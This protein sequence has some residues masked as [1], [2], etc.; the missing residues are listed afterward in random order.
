MLSC[1]VTSC[2]QERNLKY[3]EGGQDASRMTAS[4]RR[5]IGTLGTLIE[6]LVRALDAPECASL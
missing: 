5:K 1:P 6:K 4:A 2:P 3:P